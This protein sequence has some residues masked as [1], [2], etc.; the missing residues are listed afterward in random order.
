MSPVLPPPL[1]HTGTGSRP[2][3]WTGAGPGGLRV[4]RDDGEP[5]ALA[6]LLSSPFLALAAGGGQGHMTQRH[7]AQW[8]VLPG[9][10][11]AWG[12]DMRSSGRQSRAHPAGSKEGP[13]GRVPAL[14]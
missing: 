7:L 14:G 6:A 1:G 12:A 9:P 8:R 5:P 3:M 10:G 11:G 2:R 4:A 13:D